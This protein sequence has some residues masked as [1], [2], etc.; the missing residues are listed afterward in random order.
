MDD[1]QLPAVAETYALQPQLSV[2]QAQE[3]L[4]QLQGFVKSYMQ[5]DEDYG[6]IPGTDKPTLL[7]PGADKL[8]EIYGFYTDFTIETSIE[9]WDRPFPLFDYT[10]KCTIRRKRDNVIVSTGLG[11]CNSMEGKY[12]WRMAK[13]R[14]PSCGAEAIIKGKAEYGGGWLCF[15]KQGGCGTKFDDNDQAIVSQTVGQVE[16]EDIATQKNTILKMAKKRAKVDAVISAT[17]SSG[18]FT[19]DM[20][21]I[22][23]VQEVSKPAPGATTQQPESVP[24]PPKV[25]PVTTAEWNAMKADAYARGWT[26][27]DVSEF[28]H[29]TADAGNGARAVIEACKKAFSKPAPVNCDMA[30]PADAPL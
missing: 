25:A 19:Q 26:K 28:M 11:S 8:C 22:V 27:E 3:Q 1:K 24:A 12:R 17:R 29:M 2:Q 6:K 16:N 20:E 10:V 9:D 30:E 21:D 4:Q 7:N 13:R 14:C 5:E 15:K 23:D 18:L